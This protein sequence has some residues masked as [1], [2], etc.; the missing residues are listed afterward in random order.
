MNRFYKIAVL[1]LLA[2]TVYAQL[3]GI[4]YQAVILSRESGQELPGIDD[5]FENL[6]RNS[7]VSIKFTVFDQFLDVEYSETHDS[8]LV[9]GY[10]MINLVVGDGY[11]TNSEFK[12]INWDLTEKWL[13]VDIDFDGGSDFENLDYIS[14]RI[15]PYNTDNQQLS[16]VDSVLILENGSSVDLRPL[17]Q[18]QASGGDG[19]GTDDQGLEQATLTGTNLQ[20]DI[21]NGASTN[22]NLTPLAS[23]SVFVSTIANDTVFL[24][25]IVQ[26]LGLNRVEETAVA[27]NGQDLFNTPENITD[28]SLIRVYRNGVRIDFNIIDINTIQLEAEAICFQ[29][30][31]IRIEQTY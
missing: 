14:L 6:L 12:Q 31:L 28:L 9:D 10:G 15:I 18:F 16:L 24:N 27:F 19:I 13:D 2:N 30:D 11:A 21:E 7:K 22:V 29:N 3:P 1:L 26:N 5:D 23:D 25:Q 20:I 4:P 8:V 17:L